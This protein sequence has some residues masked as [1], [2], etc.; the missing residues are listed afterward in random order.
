MMRHRGRGS[1][2]SRVATAVLAALGM[3]SSAR[4]EPDSQTQSA[5]DAVGFGPSAAAPRA[6]LPSAEMPSADPVEVPERSFPL[7]H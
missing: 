3:V 2:R 4:A 7:P 6:D 5:E 1:L